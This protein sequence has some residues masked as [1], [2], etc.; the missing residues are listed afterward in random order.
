MSNITDYLTLASDTIRSCSQMEN[1][2]AEV[3]AICVAQLKKGNKIIIC[4]NGGSAADCEHIVGELMKG[5]CLPR[6]LS[7]HDRYQLTAICGDDAS[8][9]RG[10]HWYGRR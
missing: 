10:S 7:A 4:G 8:A 6:S 9:C 1:E 2:I 5:F 3:A